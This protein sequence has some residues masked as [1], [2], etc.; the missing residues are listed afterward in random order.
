MTPTLSGSSALWHFKPSEALEICNGIKFNFY[1]GLQLV[2]KESFSWMLKKSCH[3]LCVQMGWLFLN[4]FL[5][6]LHAHPWTINKL[7]LPEKSRPLC[8]VTYCGGCIHASRL[9]SSEH[10][11]CLWCYVGI[12]G[13]CPG[14]AKCGM[15]NEM[16][17]NEMVCNGAGNDTT[18]FY[19]LPGITHAVIMR[20]SPIP[21]RLILRGSL[22]LTA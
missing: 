3:T 6:T 11:Q 14:K 13:Q 21:L 17:W 22:G 9:L 19:G 16:V 15:R 4:L 10:T 8:K 2:F 1:P 20:R 5:A 12:Y 7:H 18:L